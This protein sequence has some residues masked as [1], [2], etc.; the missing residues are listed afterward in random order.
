MSTD[1]IALF[2]ISSEVVDPEWLQERLSADPEF[3]APILERYWNAWQV[4]NW[5]IE[6]WGTLG[7]KLLGPGGFVI[8]FKPQTLEMYHMMR[9]STFTGDA[10]CR[11]DLRSACLTIAKFV[12]SVHAIYTHELMP[13]EGEGLIQIE[14]GLRARIGP[15]AATFEE[16]HNAEYYGSRA[17]YIDTFED[18]QDAR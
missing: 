4:K 10:A 16:L 6:N 5:K 8:G 11:Q 17:W 9:F 1:F 3:A 13:Y 2:D 7:S 12:G 14:S 15:P 18:L